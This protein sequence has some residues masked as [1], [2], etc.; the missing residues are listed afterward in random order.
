[1]AITKYV[2]R[3]YRNS[4]IWA[5]QCVSETK[6]TVAI[7]TD[8]GPINRR[9][10]SVYEKYHDTWEAAR[11]YL[12]HSVEREKRFAQSALCAAEDDL[13][14]IAALSKGDVEIDK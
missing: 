4:S 2:T 11:D 5:V 7:Q 1:M 3:N 10:E 12:M 14:K 6:T 9:K 13:R 8:D